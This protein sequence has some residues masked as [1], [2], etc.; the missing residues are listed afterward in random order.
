MKAAPV[1]LF[2]YN[3]PE[4]TRRTVEALRNNELAGATPLIIFSDGPRDHSMD[5]SVQEVRNYISTVDGFESIVIH[6][7]KKNMGLASS[8]IQGVTEVA[9]ESG[10][11]IVLEDDLVTAPS[12]LSYMN[13]ALSFYR[14]T[15]EVFSISGYNLPPQTMKIAADYPYDV[16]F[17]PRAH[18]WGWGTWA[19]R[20]AKADWQVNDFKTFIAD[21]EQI[22]QFHSGGEDLTHMLQLQM[23]G[24]IDSWAIRWCYTHFREH[25]FCVYPT[26]SLVENIGFDG[27]GVHCGASGNDKYYAPLPEG[28]QRFN[29]SMVIQTNETLMDDFRAAYRP[30]RGPGKFIRMLKRFKQFFLKD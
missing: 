16:Y 21:R 2:T 27:S 3:R 17:N 11:V 30:A 26:R 22:R 14:D 28:K 15:P 5:K 7:R 9:G 19:D 25:A 23:E 1:A 4:H 13:E 24:R 8:I 29:F 18:S 6:H 10:R 12:F 20:W